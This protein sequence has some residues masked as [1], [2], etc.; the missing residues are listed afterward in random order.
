[1][2]DEH[3]HLGTVLAL[4]EDLR[5]D[6]GTQV[7]VDL[8]LAEQCALTALDVIPVDAVR[9]GEPGEGLEGLVV[10]QFAVEAADASDT[11]KL[12][13]TLQLALQVEDL[14]L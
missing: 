11:G 14:D 8:G 1:M 13:L 7:H 10:V 2:H 12:D 3:R 4:E 6:E 5:G 9:C